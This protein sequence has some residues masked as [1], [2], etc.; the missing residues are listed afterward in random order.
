MAGEFRTFTVSGGELCTPNSWVY[1]W[2]SQESGQ[3]V[4]VGAT[5]LDPEARTWMHLH[6]ESSQ[7]G[8]VRTRYPQVSTEPMEVLAF[9]VPD[10]VD[11]AAAKELLVRRFL[12]IGVLSGNHICDEPVDAIV[13]PQVEKFVRSV[14]AELRAN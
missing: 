2:A 11:R 12:S 6:D 10:D 3:V 1:I 4:Y 8:K 14:L 9:A 7:G 5:R 13:T